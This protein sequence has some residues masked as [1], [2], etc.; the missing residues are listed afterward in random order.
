[1][2]LG[3]RIFISFTLIFSLGFYYPITW[4]LDNLRI[5][6][7]EGV[8]EPLVDQANILAS[9]IGRDMEENRFDR[10]RLRSAVNQA[11]KRKLS[12]RIYNLTKK[13]VDV[14]IY[15]TD[16]NGQVIFDSF[17][18]DNEG[19]DYSQ[20]RDV[21]LTLNGEYG[22]R[23][24]RD[25]PDDEDSSVLYVGAPIRVNQEL[26]GVLTVAKPTTN[27]NSFLKSAR[28]R[29]LKVVV[30]TAM[31]VIVLCS[32]VS[33]WLTRPIQRLTEFARNV[34][35]GKRVALPKL[36]QSEIGEMGQAFEEMRETLEGKKYIEH[37]V[38]TLTHEIKSPLSA[39]SGA[40]ELLEEDMLPEKR[41]HF[42]SNIRNETSR[43]K[44][45]VDRMLTLSS[46]EARKS[47][48]RVEPISLKELVGQ[49]IERYDGSII[50]KNLTV[51]ENVDERIILEGDPMLLNLAVSNLFKNAIDFSGNNDTIRVDGQQDLD[52]V[53]LFVRDEGPGFPEYAAARLYEK[54]F[55]L[56]RPDSGKKS[57]GLGLNFVKETAQLHGGRVVLE[58]RE[59][60]G[61]RACLILPRIKQGARGAERMAHGA[62]SK[63]TLL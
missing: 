4:M 45:F 63:L 25:D 18:P 30:L 11:Y 44:S 47:L 10:E 41:L 46:L 55:S 39:I 7:L 34:R 23:S 61:V 9:L 20:W 43:I 51:Q 1:M 14:R 57:T 56:P 24:T 28:P 8:E 50:A 16:K 32:I 3:T 27:I 40:V 53:R 17:D 22:A 5:R 54:F 31:I 49:V 2:K 36:D 21:F 37:Y 6:Y 13:N 35:D 38:N 19:S 59:N 52:E 58:N 62:K 29:I 60:G 42:L 26:A 33:V 15:V 48:E 12:S